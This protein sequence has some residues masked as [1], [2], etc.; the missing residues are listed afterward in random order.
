M[1]P[2]QEDSQEDADEMDG[3]LRAVYRKP[4]TNFKDKQ[5]YYAALNKALEK[6]PAHRPFIEETPWGN[7]ET[8]LVGLERHFGEPLD[9]FKPSLATIN[10]KFS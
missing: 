9:K 6:R 4:W 10:N 3:R 7:D 8:K 5:K 2:D 1:H